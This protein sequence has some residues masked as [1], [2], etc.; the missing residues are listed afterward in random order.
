MK[1]YYKPFSL[2]KQEELEVGIASQFE[3]DY[4]CP[5]RLFSNCKFCKNVIN[6]KGVFP[7]LLLKNGQ[8]LSF[9]DIFACF[10]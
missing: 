10:L 8:K 6:I 1:A 5:T 7:D 3:E 2:Y 9:S 4:L